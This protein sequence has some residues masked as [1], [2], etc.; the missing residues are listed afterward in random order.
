V[1]RV[2]TDLQDSQLAVNF[3]LER[4]TEGWQVFS[5]TFDPTR[6]SSQRV[7]DILVGAGAVVIPAPVSD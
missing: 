3:R 4:A 1:T 6:V 2:A 7:T 5:V